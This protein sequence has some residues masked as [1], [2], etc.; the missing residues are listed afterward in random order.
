MKTKKEKGKFW[1]IYVG[2]AAIESLTISRINAP[3]H[4]LSR[5]KGDG[6]RVVGIS[7]VGKTCVWTCEYAPSH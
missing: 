4:V 1:A 6:Y 5:L 3:Y 2:V 7:P